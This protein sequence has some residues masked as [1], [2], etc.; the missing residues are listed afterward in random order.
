MNGR[1]LTRIL[2]TT[3]NLFRRSDLRIVLPTCLLFLNPS[4]VKN[5]LRALRE[6]KDA[7]GCLGVLETC[8]RPN[9]A[10]IESSR[11]V[12]PRVNLSDLI[13]EIDCTVKSVS[14]VSNLLMALKP[15]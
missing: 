9:F 6:K 2:F 11:S 4:Q 1:R 14:L 15:S 3:G 7:R 12:V 13:L 8:T 10:A 5:L